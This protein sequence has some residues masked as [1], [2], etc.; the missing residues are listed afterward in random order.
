MN[1]L[2]LLVIILVIFAF[3]GAPG[4]GPW[5]HNYGWAPSGTGL[6]IVIIIVVLLLSGRL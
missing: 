3:V 1:L 4:Y 2:W 5:K 6:V